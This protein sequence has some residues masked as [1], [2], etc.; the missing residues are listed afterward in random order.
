MTE[1]EQQQTSVKYLLDILDDLLCDKILWDFSIYKQICI[2][3][4]EKYEKELKESFEKGYEE[5]VK[6]TDGLISHEKF[7]F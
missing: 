2:S 5:G 1:Q 6:Y 4:R 3:A 7:P